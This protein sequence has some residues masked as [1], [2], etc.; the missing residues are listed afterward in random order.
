MPTGGI[1]VNTPGFWAG[2]AV[3]MGGL[4]GALKAF[5]ITRRLDRMDSKY[6]RMDGK[7]D[8]LAEDVAFLR[9]RAKG[10]K[11]GG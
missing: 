4:G 1:D 2:V 3:V 7:L 8:K 6:D 9:G 11:E 10:A 5:Q